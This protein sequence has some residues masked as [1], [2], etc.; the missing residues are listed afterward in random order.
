[1]LNMSIIREAKLAQ[2]NQTVLAYTP[3]V[4]AS[5]KALYAKVARVIPEIEWPAFAPLIVEDRKSTR[6][7]SSHG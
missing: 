2:A 5:T 4:A 3:E 1:M 7:N 6:L